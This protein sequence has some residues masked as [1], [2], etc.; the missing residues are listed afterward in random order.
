M[1]ELERV[2][3]VV[4][5]AAARL[6][7]ADAPD[8]ELAEYVPERRKLGIT[9]SPRMKPIGR[10]WRLGVLLVDRDGTLYA[11]GSSTRAIEPGR[12]NH[13]SISGEERR[14]HRAAAHRSYPEG[15]VVN[16]GA[17]V[18]DLSSAEPEAPLL[19]PKSPLLLVGGRVLVRW[20]PTAD[21]S[22]APEFETYLRERVELLLSPPQGT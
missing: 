17:R 18:I 3:G 1:R 15:T 2:R 14:M 9:F 7:A 6:A 8:E 10:A 13:Q 19:T 12:A 22:N 20:S 21:A 5:D 4:A 11:A 16:F